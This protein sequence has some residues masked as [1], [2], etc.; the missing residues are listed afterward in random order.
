[1]QLLILTAFYPIPNITHERMFVHVRNCYYQSH[2]AEVTVLN[3]AASEDYFIDNIR[4]ITLKTFND[5]KKHYDIV[6]SH[7]ANIRNHYRFLKKYNKLFDKLVFF[8]HG[9][10]AS[11]LAKDYPKPYVFMPDNNIFRHL[12]RY[13]YDLVKL[14]LWSSYYKSLAY[15][16]SFIFV[17][18]SFYKRALNNMRI[19]EKD[20]QYHCY[21][22]NNS[23]GTFF[24]N[25][26]YDI[27]S[28]KDFDFICIRSNID[29][30]KYCVDLFIA[31]AN[32]YKDKKFLL[33]GKGNIFKFV[34][35]PDNLLWIDNTLSHE[36]ILKYLNKSKCGIMLTRSDTQ[37]V[38]TCELASIGMPVISSNIEVCQEILK[39]FSNVVLVPNDIKEFDLNAV[40][41]KLVSGLPY[42]KCK[43]YYAEET[44]EKEMLLFK[45]I[46]KNKCSNNKDIYCSNI[47][48]WR[49][50]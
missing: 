48:A 31:L 47:V 9:H 37:G 26:N 12:F 1:M 42:T 20:L 2:G 10:E 41:Q 30:S 34:K 22:I 28:K 13:I 49:I 39:N 46:L 38:M 25:I 17:S 50:K 5:L 11:I 24:E 3:F 43:E 32:K 8:F 36:D 18:N 21:V 14:K 45:E 19:T 16:S 7:S 44:I 23:I 15:K 27:E 33:I 6:I 29:A 4:V 40:Y 35:K